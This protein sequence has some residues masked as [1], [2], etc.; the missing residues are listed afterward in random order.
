MTG[1]QHCHDDG[2]G[3]ANAEAVATIQLP[4]ENAVKHS[5]KAEMAAPVLAVFGCI[6]MDLSVLRQEL[7]HDTCR[8]R[9]ALS[10][11]AL[12]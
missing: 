10:E 6:P 8:P 12:G 11:N 5:R 1:R 3:R 9:C 7:L 4:L 2:I